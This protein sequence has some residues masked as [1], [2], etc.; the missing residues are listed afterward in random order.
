MRAPGEYLH[1]QKPNLV[2]RYM[3]KA[4]P[5]LSPALQAELILHVNQP[6]IDR[7]WF[8]RGLEP[9]CLV[10]LARELSA[11]VFAPGELAP[12]GN[13]YVV[14]RGHLFFGPFLLTR[15][16]VWGDDVILSSS[17]YALPYPARAVRNAVGVPSARLRRALLAAGL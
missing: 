15:G 13:L 9:A 2:Q 3:E 8:L 5:I 12:L 16:M 4:I 7:A 17:R 11:R 10:R 1:E 6:W 14:R